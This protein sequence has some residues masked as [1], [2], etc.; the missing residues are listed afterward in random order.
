MAVMALLVS[1]T[2]AAPSPPAAIIKEL[3]EMI[4]RLGFSQTVAMKLVD[5][6]GMDSQQTL[7]CLSDKD[8]ITICDM[9]H[10]PGGLVS[11]KTL[12]RGNQ[13]SVLATKK[14]KLMAFMFNTMKHCSKDYEIICVNRISVLQ[15][16]HQ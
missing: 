15:Y 3:K 10:R 11:M 8:T 16:Q 9:I 12:D 13:I 5:D 6:Q 7:A 1:C 4:L 14:L 2:P